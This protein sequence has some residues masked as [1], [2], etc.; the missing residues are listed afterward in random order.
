M[1][2]V[3]RALKVLEKVVVVYMSK[4]GY[5]VATIIMGLMTILC[6]YTMYEKELADSKIK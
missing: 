6:K 2:I 1:N 3:N 4:R 5:V